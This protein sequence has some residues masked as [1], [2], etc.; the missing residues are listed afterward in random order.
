MPYMA[1]Y[2]LYCAVGLAVYLAV[3][4]GGEWRLDH[5]VLLTIA[6]AVIVN[7]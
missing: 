6:P 7:I 4:S 5:L 2:I 1:A 3:T